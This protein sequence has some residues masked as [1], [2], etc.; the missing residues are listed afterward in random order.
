[1]VAS[2]AEGQRRDHGRST[3]RRRHGERRACG[4]ADRRLR[5]EVML[6]IALMEW[7]GVVGGRT[8]ERRRREQWQRR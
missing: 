6:A 2:R 4:V 5:R 7:S 8:R 1:M 3:R